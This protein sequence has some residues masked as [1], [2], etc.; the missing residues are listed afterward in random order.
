M[1][2]KAVKQDF[3]SYSVQFFLTSYVLLPRSQENRRN[4]IDFLYPIYLDT[5]P[6]SPLGPAITAVG[7]LL[8]EGWSLLKPDAP[9]SFSRAQYMKAV[10]SLRRSLET[11]KTVSDDVL[12][13]ALLLDMYESVSAFM[14]SKTYVDS[15]HMDGVVAMI[16]Q[17]KHSP[18][19]S[20][21]SR[22]LLLG[23]RH[24]IIHRALHNNQPVPES[25]LECASLIEDIPRTAALRLDEL[26]IA[27]ANISASASRLNEHD[28]DQELVIE[29]LSRAYE[30]DRRYH[31]WGD[32]VPDGWIVEVSGPQCIPWSVQQSGL[33]QDYCHIYQSIF[34]AH[35]FNTFRVSRIELQSAILVCLTHLGDGITNMASR[36]AIAI[37][38]SMADDICASIPYHL[39]DRMGFRRIDDKTVQY[40]HLP[41]LSKAD[42]EHILGAAAMGGWSLAQQLIIVLRLK[43]PLRDGQREW[44][45]G[46]LHRLTKVYSS[47]L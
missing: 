1:R 30:L 3:S 43:S 5:R 37:I 47:P 16:E 23:A 32:S 7:S 33:Y 22:K 18:G 29:L 27:L 41:T 46:Q 31:A 44:I 35:T 40:P 45:V 19:A 8:L 21:T 10:A 36:A 28:A 6:G 15:P 17:R 34:V 12:T 11:S 26:D 2:L 38:Q 13:S 14:W 42:D 24:H 20:T 39:G 9:S 25:M 4:F